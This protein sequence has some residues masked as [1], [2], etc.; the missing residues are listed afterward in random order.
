MR[1]HITCCPPPSCFRLNSVDIVFPPSSTNP[2]PLSASAFPIRLEPPSPCIN[3]IPV[4]LPTTNHEVSRLQVDHTTNAPILTGLPVLSPYVFSSPRP[5]SVSL[6]ET[7]APRRPTI[8]ASVQGLSTP[9]VPVDLV[10]DHTTKFLHPSHCSQTTTSSQRS[11]AP[12]DLIYR[13]FWG[14]CSIRR[15]RRFFLLPPTHR[16]PSSP[17]PSRAAFP[18]CSPLSTPGRFS[19]LDIGVAPCRSPVISGGPDAITTSSSCRAA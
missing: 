9:P 2:F 6:K 8:R 7:A 17:P 13:R 10:F 19:L 3:Y 1:P 16:A 18:A 12:P 15:P 11:C 14:R 4:T 5:G